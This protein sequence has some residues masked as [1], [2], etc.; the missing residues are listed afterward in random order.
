MSDLKKAL[1]NA[2]EVERGA[3]R[4]YQSLASS[5]G[6]AEARA[7]LERM[8]SDEMAHAEALE[9]KSR[10]LA[11]GKLPDLPDFNMDRVE[12]IPEWRGVEGITY[13]QALNVALEAEQHAE[14]FYD[15]L[16]DTAEGAVQ[17]F[18]REMTKNEARH[19]EAVAKQLER[20]GT[21]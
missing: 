1:R 18:F 14:L 4:F 10:E 3:A 17:E 5:A 16:A 15:A 20:Y 7:F 12:A 11:D 9:Q 6:D 13:E 19:V 2:I 8:V 21:K